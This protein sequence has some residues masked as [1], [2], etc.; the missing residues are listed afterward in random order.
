[1]NHHRMFTHGTVYSSR[2]VVNVILPGTGYR[3]EGNHFF[4][5]SRGKAMDYVRR[6]IRETLTEEF[7]K[8]ADSFE[9]TAYENSDRG[10]YSFSVW[11]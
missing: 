9:I 6:M 4:S 8:L 11:V 5:P 10:H 7:P 3:G 1:M 2:E